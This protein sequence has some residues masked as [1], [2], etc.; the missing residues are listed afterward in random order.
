MSAGR[1]SS[2]SPSLTR[3]VAQFCLIVSMWQAP[4]PFVHCHGSDVSQLPAPVTTM[5]FG[6]HLSVFHAGWNESPWRDFGWH[7]HWILPFSGQDADEPPSSNQPIRPDVGFDIATMSDVGSISGDMI[8][9][10]GDSQPLLM[11]RLQSQVDWIGRIY[12]QYEPA[13][14]LPS[15]S[16]MRC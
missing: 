7:C 10:I 3:L 5:E 15:N 11:P 16:V 14:R 13:V 12:D 2:E 6:Q 8:G 9:L 4:I 1:K